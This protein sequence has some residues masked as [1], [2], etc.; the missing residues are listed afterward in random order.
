M[1]KNYFLIAFRSL[2]K[3][4]AIA[5]INIFG[6]SLG[7]AC[8]SLILL[9]VVNEFNYDRFHTNADHIY[10]VY[11]HIKDLQDI[12]EAK[13]PYMPMPLGPALKADFPEEVANTVRLREP[14]GEDFVR[15]PHATTT[16]RITYADPSFFEMFS[17]PI[18]KG[19]Q[20]APLQE[21]HAVVLSA[22]TAQRLFG[23][24]N[25]VGKSLE[26]KVE[27]DFV[28]FTVTAVAANP[29]S[30]SSIQFDVLANYERLYTTK[31]GQRS[32]DN[33]NRSGFLTFVALKSHSNLAEQTA[34]LLQFR[35]KYYPTEVADLEIVA[36][37]TGKK[38]SINFGLQPLRSMHTD[39]TVGGGDVP[40]INPRY[41]L[42]L[43][44]IG[45]MILVIACINF[46]T[47]SIGRSASR[48][49][50]VGVRKVVG[51][52]RQQ[53]FAQFLTESF[54][55]TIIS[56]LIGFGLGRILMPIFNTL[57]ARELTWDFS[58]FP[59]MLP[60]L[61][62]LTLTVALLAGA[63]PALILS[64][65][66]PVEIL[67]RKL[68]LKGANWFTNSLVSFQFVLSISL[69]VSTLI[70]LQQLNFLSSKN[71]GFS[72]EN[73]LVINASN[74]DTERIFPRLRQALQGSREIIGVATAE[75][76]L[77]EGAGW[78]RTGFEYKGQNKSVY[79]YH[80]DPNY[81]NVLGLDIIAGR[82][83]DYNYASDS[84]NAIIINEAMMKDMGWTLENAVGQQITGYSEQMTP[85]VIGVVKDFNF[86]SLHEN[87]EPMMFQMFADYQPFQMLVRLRPGNP[88]PAI[89]EIEKAWQSAA[90]GLPF[91][92]SFLDE[93]IDRFY[94]AE[95]RWGRI[96]GVAGSIC[97]LLACMGLL[98]LTSLVV[99]NRTK[100]IG[101]RKVLGASV[102]NILTL[103]SKDFLRLIIIAAVIA[104]PLAWWAMSQWLQD[105][106]YRID[107]QWWMFAEAGVITLFIALL[108]ITLQAMRTAVANPVESLRNE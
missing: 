87:I 65:F 73:V 41:P 52:K 70:M 86:R 104:V 32:I 98:G 23:N 13:D 80:I 96:V 79:E 30:N 37:E 105:F 82:N 18:L 27:E 77:G 97:I 3:N 35:R 22:K 16:A 21:L 36:K 42:V 24:E 78:S 101:I 81:V 71:P 47:L 51:A 108:T 94:Q 34:R 15:T 90:P 85:T 26:I 57:A 45:A 55:L 43:L 20:K 50:E 53:L 12:D 103:L 6:L 11:R 62:A 99:V 40:P 8:F 60:L 54:L 91:Q 74:T 39:P 56:M 28:S 31:F 33:W 93:N 83:F 10:R 89:Q 95:Q 100:E 106:A 4:K 49:R 84:M 9:Y 19:N 107:I 92:Y 1:L 48:T 88:A 7:L 102:N 69:V 14:W 61:A 59:E 75:I 2:W 76:S 46:T 58:Q 44:G 25:P 38:P 5:G 29:P 67:K 63:Y 66:K 64:S 68:R 17:F 72:K